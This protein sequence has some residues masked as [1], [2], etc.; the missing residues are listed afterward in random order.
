MTNTPKRQNDVTRA[1]EFGEKARAIM[2]VL[3]DLDPTARRI[4]EF[5]CKYK[6]QYDGISPSYAEII[7]ACNLTS[8]S[9]V[10]WHIDKLVAAGLIKELVIET[11]TGKGKS[12][13][14]MVVSGVWSYSQ[15]LMEALVNTHDPLL[16]RERHRDGYEE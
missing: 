14:L 7:A 15:E 4:F 10:T 9:V 8:T 5:V 12:R 13:G 16:V 11:P 3:H 1:K 2:K 6:R